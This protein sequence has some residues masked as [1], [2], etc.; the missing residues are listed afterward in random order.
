MTIPFVV[1]GMPRSRTHWLSRF[2]SYG[3]W[4]CEHEA[5]AKFR[6]LD[7]V[8]SWLSQDF[9]GSVETAA[10]PF[11]RL[12][13]KYRSDA[14]VAVVFR[15]VSEV[16]DSLMRLDMRGVVS[17]DR[18]SVTKAML[19]LEAKLWQIV[20]RVPDA[21]VVTFAELATRGGCRRIFEHCLQL[22]F[23]RVWWRS[24]ANSNLQCSM[25]AMMRYFMAHKPQIDRMRAIAKQTTLTDFALRKGVS[26]DG[27]EI[28]IEP[29]ASFYEDAQSLFREHLANVGE[30]PEAFPHKS[31]PLYQS[32]D[33]AGN[34]QMT[35][36]RQ[37]G[38]IFGYLMTVE[39]PS[40]E[41]EGER[42]GA[43][44]LRYASPAFPGLG[45]K[46][47][48]F[49]DANAKKRALAETFARAGTRGAADRTAVIFDRC[50]YA[51][52]GTMHRLNLR[53]A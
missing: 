50:G 30:H 21:I 47:Q 41:R 8:K 38:R 1:F 25:P 31:I 13:R 20:A 29:F 28:A 24:F 11:W 48:R 52:D 46:L 40:F 39:S 15:P 22:P 3:D 12:L 10:A 14:R 37:N 9:T 4:S 17:F 43:H 6:G 18:E 27:V 34:L 23:D 45:L 44:T 2:L 26:A 33:E 16:V 49:A 19:R 7:D 53:E 42:I 32:L 35:V 36:A 51:E 5:V